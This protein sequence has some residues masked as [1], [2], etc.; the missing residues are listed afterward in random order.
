MSL[1]FISH[2]RQYTKP[3]METGMIEE[4]V[5]I[6]GRIRVALFMLSSKHRTSKT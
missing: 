1:I 4:I 6:V 2:I 5:F 3:R